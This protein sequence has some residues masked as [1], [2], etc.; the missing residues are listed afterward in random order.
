M[1]YRY[2]TLVFNLTIALSRNL[3]TPNIDFERILYTMA[4]NIIVEKLHPITPL[5]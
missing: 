1:L 3:E 5:L 2:I 4:E